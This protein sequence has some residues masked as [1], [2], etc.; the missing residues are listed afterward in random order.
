[1][2]KAVTDRMVKSFLDLFVLDLLD[3]GPKHGYE[4]MRELKNRTGTTIG[5]G[6]L[7]PLLYELEE[8]E[9]VD[10]EWNSPNRRSRKIYKI[11]DHG[12]KY[13]RQ[14]FR[15]IGMLVRGT[16]RDSSG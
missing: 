1:M 3:T 10:G 15:G 4:I 13:K 6:T 16:D 9:F 11:T 8:R 12:A 7:Y 14:G 5:A 2:S